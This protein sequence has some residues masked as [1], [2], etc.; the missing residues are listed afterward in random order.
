MKKIFFYC[1][2]LLAGVFA[3]TSC[4]TKDDVNYVV[5]YQSWE[6][7]GTAESPT[8]DGYSVIRRDDGAKLI[9]L[10][11]NG[12]NFNA[13]VGQRIIF[14]YDIIKDM[15]EGDIFNKTYTIALH[16]ALKILTKGVVDQ[17]FINED[18]THRE[19]SLGNDPILKIDKA[20]FSGKF[21]NLNLIYPYTPSLGVSH[22]LSLVY[23]NANSDSTA[24]VVLTLHHN[25]YRD[26]INNTRALKE[27]R[28]SYN[29]IYTTSARTAYDISSILPEGQT[30]VKI[31]LKRVEYNDKLQEVV[32]SSEATFRLSPDDESRSENEEWD[33]I[34]IDGPEYGLD[35]ITTK[36]E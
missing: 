7:Y 28:N 3:T 18:P 4:S 27:T 8:K 12:D 24:V 17:S 30:S 21:L 16:D 34:L 6:S 14:S 13:E 25:A 20:W 26:T 33:N 36:V 11:S 22:M 31:V 9:I 19:D 10:Y 5:N 29:S 23:D 2:V 35:K 1:A 32:R 15:S